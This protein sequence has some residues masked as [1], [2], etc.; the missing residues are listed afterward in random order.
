MAKNGK[1]SDKRD[2]KGK[3]KKGSQ[4]ASALAPIR[5]LLRSAP[6]AMT[7]AAGAL[8]VAGITSLWRVRR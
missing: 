7:V 8:I 3:R 1:K 2:K 5:D 6:A 4:S